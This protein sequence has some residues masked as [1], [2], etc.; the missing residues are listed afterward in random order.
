MALT[1][2]YILYCVTSVTSTREVARWDS[3]FPAWAW[4]RFSEWA[5]NNLLVPTCAPRNFA[6]LGGGYGNPART[7]FSSVRAFDLSYRCTRARDLSPET[8]LIFQTEPHPQ[9]QLLGWQL[10]ESQF[11]PIA[12]VHVRCLGGRLHSAGAGCKV[13]LIDATP[14]LRTRYLRSPNRPI[15]L[16]A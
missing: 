9:L 4:S 13:I 16:T 12:Y 5:A 8:P 3:R 1:A 6:S 14:L 11:L 15:P 2:I 7:S 10:P